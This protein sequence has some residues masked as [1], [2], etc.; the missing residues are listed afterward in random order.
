M[1]K[2]LSLG[3]DPVRSYLTPVTDCSHLRLDRSDGVRRCP[4]AIRPETTQL[5]ITPE[6]EAFVRGLTADEVYVQGTPSFFGYTGLSF[7]T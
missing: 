6:D 3:S 4:S 5:T 1:R 7:G 2:N